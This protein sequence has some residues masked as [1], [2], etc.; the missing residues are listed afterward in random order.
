V[1][2]AV[3]EWHIPVENSTCGKPL[4][5]YLSTQALTLFRDV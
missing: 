2:L 5:V 4:I 1:H 3:G